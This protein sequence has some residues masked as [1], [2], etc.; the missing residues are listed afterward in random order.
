M[1][2]TLH[3]PVDTVSNNDSIEIER[4][5]LDVVV[6]GSNWVTRVADTVAPYF[7]RDWDKMDRVTRASQVSEV[8]EFIGASAGFVAGLGVTQKLAHKPLLS[9]ATGFLMSKAAEG[10]SRQYS[11]TK[12]N[13]K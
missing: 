4:S 13:E 12:Y 10:I 2:Y 6:G 1:A 8:G 3:L 9:M 11:F 7:N 5:R